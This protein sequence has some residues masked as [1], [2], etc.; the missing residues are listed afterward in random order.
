MINGKLGANPSKANDAKTKIQKKEVG[1]G[2]GE[3]LIEDWQDFALIVEHGL[4]QQMPAKYLHQK[5]L[6][7]P[8]LRLSLP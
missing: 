1:K 2:G 8:M 5:H 4:N 3:E 6:Q 7:Q